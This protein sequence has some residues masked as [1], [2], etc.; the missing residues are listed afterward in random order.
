MRV[1]VELQGLNDA[2]DDLRS[3]A[4]DADRAAFVVVSD[5]TLKTREE[6]INGIERGPASGRTY[7]K[8][9]PRRV[10]QASA[11]GQFP[12]TDTGRLASS[13]RAIMPTQ[14][15]IVGKVGTNV[16]YGAHLQWGTANM[17]ARPWL[18]VALRKAAVRVEERLKR[19]F[20]R[21]AK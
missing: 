12:M 3:V 18:D 17:A 19:E 1:K 16:H 13:V 4:R 7:R 5:L 6:A 10:H 15:R 8:Y 11:P 20:E 2:L 9:N 14:E 21:R